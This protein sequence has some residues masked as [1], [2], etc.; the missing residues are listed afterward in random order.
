MTKN[1][2][3]QDQQSSSISSSART[4]RQALHIKLLTLS[5]AVVMLSRTVSCFTLPT[6]SHP[7]QMNQASTS[8]R[9]NF[10]SLIS[11]KKSSSTEL[12]V[13]WF[14]GG[15]QDNSRNDDLLGVKIERT[16]PNSR[17][18]AGE[19]IV[20]KSIED[21]WA[22]LTDYDNLAIHVPNLV[23][24]RRIGSNLSNTGAF[25]G[26][27]KYKCK[28]YQKGAQKI[29]G[30]EF[31]ASVTMEMTENIRMS[32]V[33]TPRVLKLGKE[34][35]VNAGEQRRIYFKCVDSQFFSEFDGEWKVSW[36][37]DPDDAFELAT[38]VEYV[39]DVRPKGP[40]PVQALE[41]RIREDVPTNLR[42]VKA[43]SLDLGKEGV[44]ALREKLNQTSRREVERSTAITETS[45]T[46][47]NALTP[48]PV[49]LSSNGRKMKRSQ[50]R[51]L[52]TAASNTRRNV[53]DLMNKAA[54]ASKN[55]MDVVAVS[56]Q[57]SQRKLA[58]VRVQW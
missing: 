49:S 43:A 13:R 38:K 42:A 37:T 33:V 52:A 45:S 21:V 58:P 20:S 7:Q 2:V 24:S 30:F 6:Y 5:T 47:S 15:S 1:S 4:M 23:E 3:S 26:D 48:T 44:L 29:I 55:A 25:Q 28:L 10:S 31:G 46:Q 34:K 12:K 17:R 57:S 22:I 54:S 35:D 39:V 9:S 36:T 14:G 56:Q 51:K 40:V 50:G 19:I 16:S 32:N 11:E 53:G 27:G 8:F 41:W 18:I